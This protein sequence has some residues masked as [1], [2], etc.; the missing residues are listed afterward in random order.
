MNFIPHKFQP[1][2]PNTPNTT[3]IQSH[4]AVNNS[5]PYKHH[6]T[7]DLTFS[8]IMLLLVPHIYFANTQH[9]T[10]VQSY[11]V[12]NNSSYIYFAITQCTHQTFSPITLLL[13]THNGFFNT[14][15]TSKIQCLSIPQKAPDKHYTPNI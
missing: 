1:T 15:H 13:I 14:H 7:I 5:S 3:N 12:V 10:N 4:S 6:N 2:P 8:P 9:T 11:Y